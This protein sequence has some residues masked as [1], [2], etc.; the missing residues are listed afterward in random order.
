MSGGLFYHDLALRSGSRVGGKQFV[1]E[2]GQCVTNARR[3]PGLLERHVHIFRDGDGMRGGP[4]DLTVV[5]FG[6]ARRIVQDCSL[7]CSSPLTT[8]LALD[9][10]ASGASTRMFSIFASPSVRRPPTFAAIWE[11]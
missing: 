1:E 2:Q 7:F 3:E 9:V 5:R 8:K 10:A 4:L 11:R 6:H